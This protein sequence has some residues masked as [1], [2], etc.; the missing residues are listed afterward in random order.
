MTSAITPPHLAR[1]FAQ[2]TDA[3]RRDL[4]RGL[5]RSLKKGE[6]RDEALAR[7]ERAGWSREYAAWVYTKVR[8]DGEIE[9]LGPLDDRVRAAVM[10]PPPILTNTL[11]VL[12]SIALFVLLS[13][14]LGA[15][16]GVLV[17]PTTW[18]LWRFGKRIFSKQDTGE[19]E[20]V[21]PR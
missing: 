7:A 9:L 11:G 1:D 8:K 15:V 4:V 21:T 3:E 10:A 17:V 14:T 5:L 13:L 2:S 18:G 6:T 12:A 19:S 20:W 16:V